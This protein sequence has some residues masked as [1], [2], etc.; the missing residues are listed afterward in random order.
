[1]QGRSANLWYAAAKAL[2]FEVSSMR[3]PDPLFVEH[4]RGL[5]LEVKSLAALP[6]RLRRPC[7]LP[8]V[9]FSDVES[10]PLGADAVEYWGAW[11]TTH[12]F[13]CLGSDDSVHLGGASRAAPSTTPLTPPLGGRRDPSALHTMRRGGPRRGGGRLLYGIRLTSRGLS[14]WHGLPEGALHCCAVS[15]I[16]SGRHLIGASAA[17]A[18]PGSGWSVRMVWCWILG[19][20]RHLSPQLGCWWSHRGALLAMA[21]AACRRGSWEISGTSPFSSSI[22]CRMRR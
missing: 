20:F 13:Y 4:V 9:V 8:D 10:I 1:V 5:G 18:S 16:G 19:S 22:L 21:H 7:R 14:R 11:T 12:L 3:C 15:T 17:P 2:G 6:R